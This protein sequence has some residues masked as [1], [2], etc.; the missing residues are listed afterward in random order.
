MSIAKSVV[1]SELVRGGDL[2]AV[3]TQPVIGVFATVFLMLVLLDTTG[4]QNR[5]RLD[6]LNHVTP[7]SWEGYVS[8]CQDRRNGEEVYTWE[9]NSTKYSTKDFDQNELRCLVGDVHAKQQPCHSR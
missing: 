4:L 3:G 6:N 5:T 8:G 9:N 1:D 7:K 2:L